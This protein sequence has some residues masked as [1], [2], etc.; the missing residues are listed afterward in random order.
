MKCYVFSVICLTMLDCFIGRV[1]THLS[2]VLQYNKINMRD[3][4][5]STF[6]SYIYT[7]YSHHTL[8]SVIY[9]LAK[10][11]LNNEF[12]I[13]KVF[14]LTLILS[15]N[16]L[17]VNLQ[18]IQKKW[19]SSHL[20]YMATPLASSEII[21]VTKPLPSGVTKISHLLQR[22]FLAL[23]YFHIHISLNLPPDY[24]YFLF[25]TFFSSLALSRSFSTC[26]SLRTN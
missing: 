25:V 14:F 26:L 20:N 10:H 4:A 11:F 9:F 1:L 2:Q 23:R 12:S 18:F 15:P 3:S 24:L 22:A 8:H 16:I 5:R 21:S 13:I 17:S 19:S 7:H 6:P